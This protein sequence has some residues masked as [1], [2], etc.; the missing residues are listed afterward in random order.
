MT[1]ITMTPSQGMDP[2]IMTG[3]PA[4][5]PS[6]PG[7]GAFAAVSEIVVMLL[8]D[9]DTDWSQVN[10]GALRAHLVDMD[11]LITNAQVTT[12]EVENGIEMQISLGGLGGGAVSRMVPAH[13]PV[14]KGETG[15]QSDVVVGD[16]DITWRVTSPKST[17][18]IRALGFFGLM[19]MGDHHR[20]HH[21]GMA[22]GG[23]VH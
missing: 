19:A 3:R 20:A 22:H 8:N 11:M 23:M 1:P 6:E 21:I 10:I 5:I 4:A 7:Q 13:G 15:W 12:I 2:S 17:D 14:L 18:K 9:P 16:I